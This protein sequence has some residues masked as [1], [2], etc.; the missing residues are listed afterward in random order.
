MT[1]Q[2]LFGKDAGQLRKSDPDTARSIEPRLPSQIDQSILEGLSDLEKEIIM[3]IA[4]STHE[5]VPYCIMNDLQFSMSL[6]EMPDSYN[7]GELAEVC[8]K[9]MQKHGPEIFKGKSLQEMASYRYEGEDRDLG[10]TFFSEYV[11]NVMDDLFH[12]NLVSVSGT[13]MKE[14]G[15][16]DGMVWKYPLIV[17]IAPRYIKAVKATDIFDVMYDLAY[18]AID[19]VDWHGTA[20]GELDDF[21]DGLPA[22]YRSIGH[23]RRFVGDDKAEELM[24]DFERAVTQRIHGL[25][26]DVSDESAEYIL[27]TIRRDLECLE[28]LDRKVYANAVE[29]VVA[30][31]ETIE[32]VFP[33]AVDAGEQENVDYFR[34]LF[35]E[36]D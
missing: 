4:G 33:A 31:R 22:L 7:V 25:I 36:N 28:N 1:R 21:W 27:W 12:K 8:Y 18:F 3:G 30:A 19:G 24:E 6:S 14:I 2:T 26:D 20:N 32:R 10:G 11:A 13:C 9:A 23:V 34:R 15:D 35:E 16:N 5:G 17:S 29:N